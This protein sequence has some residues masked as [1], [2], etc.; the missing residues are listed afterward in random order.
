M[1]R[2]KKTMPTTFFSEPPKVFSGGGIVGGAQHLL[3]Y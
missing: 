3:G 1:S 2:P